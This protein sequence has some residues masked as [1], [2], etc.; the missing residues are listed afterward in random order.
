MVGDRLYR[1]RHSKY[2]KVRFEAGLASYFAT[3]SQ[4]AEKEDFF[5]ALRGDGYDETRLE[6]LWD[7][8]QVADRDLPLSVPLPPSRPLQMGHM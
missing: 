7:E 6:L 3:L 8:F 4:S 2:D 1:P 5:T